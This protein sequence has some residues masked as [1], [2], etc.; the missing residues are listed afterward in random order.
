MNPLLEPQRTYTPPL[1]E[2]QLVFFIVVP[3]SRKSRRGG[4]A[5]YI[6]ANCNDDVQ[7]VL[8]S[9]FQA[10]TISV[11]SQIQLDKTTI[12]S[13]DN[14][15]TKQLS[16]TAQK[17]SRAKLYEVQVAVVG[18]N[19]TVGS[20]QTAGFFTKSRSMAVTGLTPGALYAIQVRALG[21]TTGSGDWSDP[22][23]HMCM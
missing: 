17:V 8:K 10:R 23:V 22:V 1:D 20:F 12:L 4:A 13:V 19:N 6:Q 11:R 16:V 5:H 2:S 14:G 15:H 3:G 7:L 18:A 21:G 9:G